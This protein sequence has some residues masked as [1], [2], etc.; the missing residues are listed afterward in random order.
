M[1]E[2]II[3][4]SKQELKRGLT[5]LSVLGALKEAEYGYSLSQ[6]LADLGLPIETNTLY[7]LLRRLESQALLNSFW[8][9][10]SS[11]PRKYYQV[12]D[13][14]VKVFEALS[15]SWK[16]YNNVI[17]TIEQGGLTNE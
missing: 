14:G 11:K 17:R 7:P 15:E 5:M 10:N 4:Q 13:A 2:T 1:I 6:K 3:D 8:D 9:T 16:N 12:T